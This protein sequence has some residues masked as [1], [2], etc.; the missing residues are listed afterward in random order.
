M[1]A[2][3]Y[4]YQYNILIVKRLN[5]DPP[6]VIVKKMLLKCVFSLR[7]ALAVELVLGQ[8]LGLHRQGHPAGCLE[9]GRCCCGRAGHQR[10]G[11]HKDVVREQPGLRGR[12]GRS[13]SGHP[14]LPPQS[15][16][17]EQGTSAWDSCWH[18]H[19]PTPCILPHYTGAIT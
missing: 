7:E 13:K 9:L 15:C 16:P 2:R 19:S 10:P 17:V 8:E 18:V 5:M 4:L 12:G 3:A 1:A 11:F 6:T 14:L